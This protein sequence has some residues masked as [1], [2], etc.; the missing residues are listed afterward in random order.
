MKEDEEGG[1]GRKEGQGSG[2]VPAPG[3]PAQL[4]LQQTLPSLSV[5]YQAMVDRRPPPV[6]WGGD[7]GGAVGAFFFFF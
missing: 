2:G 4:S 6:E 5:T 7:G 3:R 1:P